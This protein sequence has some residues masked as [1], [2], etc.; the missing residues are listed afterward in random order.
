MR[1][2]LGLFV[3]LMLSSCVVHKLDVVPVDL[4]E[5]TPVAVTTAVKAHLHD[6]STVVFADGVTVSDN[7]V[8]GAGILYD[9]TLE[10]SR[11]VSEVSLDDVAAMESY[12]TPVSTGATTAASAASTVGIAVLG[13]LALLALFGSCPT[14][15]SVDLAEPFLEA[16]LFS[17]SIAPSFQT[18]DIDKLGIRTTIDGKFELEIRNEMLETHYI[19]HLE[20]LE[21]LHAPQQNAYPDEKGRPIVVGS[22][23]APSNAVDQEGRDILKEVRTVDDLAWSSTNERLSTVTNED[24]LDQLYLEFDLPP[25]ADDVAMVFRMRNSLLNTVLLYDVLLKEQG[26]GALD[27]MSKDLNRLGNKIETGLWYRKHM[28]L[29][30]AVWDDGHYRNVKRIGDQGPI[31]WSERAVRLRAGED[32]KLKVRLS[33]VADNWRFDRI[34]VALDS[35][36]GR[37]RIVA[38]DSAVTPEGERPDIQAHLAKADEQYLI[39]KPQDTVRLRFDVGDVAEGKARSFFLASEGYYMEWM[40]SD[41]LTQVPRKRFKPDDDTLL[42]ALNLYAAKRDGLREQFE[43]TKIEVR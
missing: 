39:T 12:Q 1:T 9:L 3:A 35:E 34:A 19:D 43:A 41:W 15:Y 18:R 40:R 26:F 42:R 33:F 23:I 16:E 24:H 13:G 7:T 10:S 21:V 8:Y 2:I 11:A 25:D 6:G 36:R 22:F 20:V 29:N 32:G 37:T 5:K 17:Y 28:G 30:I 4:A 38:V 14:V 31:A 27:W